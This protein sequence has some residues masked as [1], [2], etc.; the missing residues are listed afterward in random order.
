MFR[1]NE[2][3]LYSL[4]QRETGKQKKDQLATKLMETLWKTLLY[5]RYIG[6]RNINL[7]KTLR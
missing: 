7:I 2:Y 6:T 1:P 3:M 4:Q 5:I